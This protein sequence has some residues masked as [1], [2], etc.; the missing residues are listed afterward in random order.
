ML[1]SEYMAPFISKE[2]AFERHR[3]YYAQFVDEHV[4]Q[5]VVNNIGGREL[6]ASRDTH[7]ND[8]PLRRWDL[9]AGAIARGSRI[10]WIPRHWQPAIAFKD[11]G[12][13][14]TL[15]GLVCVLK[16]AARQWLERQEDPDVG[17]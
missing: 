1:R 15:A 11:V 9:L 2:E 7:L 12:D 13:Y 6:L 10:E 17:P 14:P 4:I 5:T 3:A 16:E 8:I